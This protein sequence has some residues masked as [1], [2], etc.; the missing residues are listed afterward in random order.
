MASLLGTAE[1]MANSKNTWHGTL[2]LVGQPAEET[3]SGAEGMIRDGVFTRFPK[4]DVAVALHV[5]NDFGPAGMVAITPGVYKTSWDAVRITIYG[6]GGI[7]A[8]P[9]RTVDPIV[10]AARTILALQ[11]IV[12]REVK[13][14]EMAI[15]TVGY[16][17]GGRRTT[18]SQM[19][20][21]WV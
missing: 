3:L 16:I 17:R 19:R 1:I 6:K 11:T 7:S 15:V 18:A 4:P 20:P 13:P 5:S 10:I 14:G 21:R 12:S 9:H 8:F 2:M